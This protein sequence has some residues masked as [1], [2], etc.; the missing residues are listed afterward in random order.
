M[1]NRRKNEKKNN[2]TADKENVSFNYVVGRGFKINFPVSS[3]DILKSLR[4]CRVREVNICGAI[5]NLCMPITKR[6]TVKME[7]KTN[8]E[9]MHMTLIVCGFW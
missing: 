4:T 7:P 6:D 8:V 1:E 3:H 9:L 5:T 2:C